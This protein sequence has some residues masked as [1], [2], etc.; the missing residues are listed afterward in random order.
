MQ[1]AQQRHRIHAAGNG[2]EN[3]PAAQQQAAAL[4]FVFD[5]LEK[6]AHALILQI[7]GTACKRS[8]QKSAS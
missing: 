8:V 6:T 5:T 4:N 2:N 3:F 7:S 1:D